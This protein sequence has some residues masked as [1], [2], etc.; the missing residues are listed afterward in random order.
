MDR[1]P[2]LEWMPKYFSKGSDKFLKDL[3]AGLVVGCMLIPQVSPSPPPPPTLSLSR[4]CVAL[5]SLAE[6][7]AM[8][9]LAG[10]L[11]ED[12]VIPPPLI[13]LSISFS[14]SLY[15]SIFLPP[16]HPPSYLAAAGDGVRG[17]RRAA[18][19]GGAL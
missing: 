7:G 11:E 17:C 4:V 18:F 2:V 12:T 16:S 8:S 10:P 9:K 5:G 19:R 13:P 14:L 15:L 3:Q 1:L 6:V